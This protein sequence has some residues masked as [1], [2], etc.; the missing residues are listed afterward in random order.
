LQKHEKVG[1]RICFLDVEATS[2]EADVG[3]TVGIGLMEDDGRFSY[4]SVD[5]PELEKNRLKNF[6]ERLERHHIIVTWNGKSFDIPF[7]VSR[8]IKHGLR[9][10]PLLSAYHLD[11]AEFVK[12]NLKLS[13]TDIFHVSK[14]LGIRKDVATLGQ[15]V[16]GL[17]VKAMKGDRVAVRR[18]ERH[19]R[20]DLNALRLIFLK[21]KPLV[22]LLKPELPI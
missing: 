11:M 1:P 2:L 22:K 21:L 16:P 12:N 7:L 13:R 8:I 15:D 5:R 19:C 18:I 20:D 10:E 9:V 3:T 6:L 14:F 17:Y 4:I